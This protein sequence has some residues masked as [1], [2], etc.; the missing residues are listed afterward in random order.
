M[1]YARGKKC[2]CSPP[3]KLQDFDGITHMIVTEKTTRWL[4]VH[5]DRKL[6]FNH[7]IKLAA[8]HGS[9][10]VN[11]LIMLAN[12]VQ[13]LSHALLRQLYLSGVAPKMLYACPTWWNNKKCQAKPLE[14]VQR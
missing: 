3:I 14:R 7:H 1:H 11:A 10:A 8:A 9:V 5:F 2:D 6:L 13:G 12:T 4:G